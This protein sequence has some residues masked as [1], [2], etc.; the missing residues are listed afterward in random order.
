MAE[1]GGLDPQRLSRPSRFE[2]APARL[3]GSPSEIWRAAGRVDRHA[4]DP[5]AP[6]GFKPAAEAAPRHCPLNWRMAEHSKLTQLSPRHRASNTRPRPRGLAILY[7]Y[8]RRDSNSHCPRS[9][10]GDSFRLVYVG[11]IGAHGAIRTLTVRSLKPFPLPVG[12][13]AR[14]WCGQS[15]LN[16]HRAGFKP[17]VSAVGLCPRCWSPV[18]E[19]N[20]ASPA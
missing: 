3:S 6:S 2:R 16:A 11:V 18:R 9:E 13:R 15:D 8:R 5:R 17:A 10:R 19:S 14:Y 20:P 7:W 4:R 1:G 12:I